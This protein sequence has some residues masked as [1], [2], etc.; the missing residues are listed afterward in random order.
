MYERD[1][2]IEYYTETGRDFPA[3]SFTSED[4]AEWDEDD[5][6]TAK[7]AMDID[8]HD[9]LYAETQRLKRTIEDLRRILEMND[10]DLDD[11]YDPKEGL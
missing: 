3:L 1:Y 11:Y 10:I 4:M 7:L 5:R 8:V 6:A 9:R 2:P